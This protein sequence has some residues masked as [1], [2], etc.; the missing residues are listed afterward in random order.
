MAGDAP[1]KRFPLNPFVRL[2]GLGVFDY[3]WVMCGSAWDRTCSEA[4]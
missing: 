2:G 3:L 4:V 1:L